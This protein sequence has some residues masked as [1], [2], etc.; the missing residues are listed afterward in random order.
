MAI[1]AIY[2][3]L[4]GL[5]VAERRVGQT[6][7]NLANV[8]TPGFVPRRLD[9]AEVAGGGVRISGSTPLAEGPIIPSE[10][11]L[12]LAING[13]GF[14]VLDDGNGGQLYSRNGNF[15]VDAQGRLVDAQ[16]RQ[17]LPPITLPAQT[18]SVRVSPQGQVQAL[19]GDG[20]VL[21]QGQIQTAVFGNPG[22]LEPVGGNAYRASAASGPPVMAAPGTPG[23]GEIVAGAMQASGTDIASSMVDL[24]IDQRAFEANLKTIKTRDDMLG[25]ILD[26]L[27]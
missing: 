20:S 8:S 7:H 16:G 27:A 21:A 9:Q 2:P 22:G 25:S 5:R 15:Q 14:F 10:R 12:D 19:A 3:A 11:P 23:H 13:G 6:A 4:S 24:I 17:A 18:A 1:D 26:V